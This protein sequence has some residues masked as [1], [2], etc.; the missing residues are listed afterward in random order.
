MSLKKPYSQKSDLE[1]IS[2]NWRKTK[3]MLLN[4][5]WSGAIVRAATATEIAANLAIREELIEIRGLDKE[6]VDSLLKWANG[7]AGK[8]DR[9]LLPVTVGDPWHPEFRKLRAQAAKLNRERNSIVHSGQFKRKS[10]AARVIPEARRIIL[11]LTAPYYD[12]YNLPEIDSK[13]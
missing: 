7:L 12:E 11:T 3:G 8:I 1:K 5:Q 10:T 6:F 13:L 4:Q 9:L 2:S